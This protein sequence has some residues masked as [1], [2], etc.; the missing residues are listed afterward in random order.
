MPTTKHLTTA[1][2]LGVALVAALSLGACATRDDISQI[3]SRLDSIDAQVRSAAQNSQAA[4]QSATNANQRLD[5]MEGRI[6]QLET[7]PARRPRG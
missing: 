5:A 7:Q 6:Q 2:S 1:R 4:N 3:N